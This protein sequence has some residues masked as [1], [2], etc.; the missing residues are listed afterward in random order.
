MGT[1]VASLLKPIPINTFHRAIVSVRGNP[2]NTY[3][4]QA[5]EKAPSDPLFIV[6]GPGSGK[7]TLLTLR[8]LKL[9]IVDQIPARAI[10]ATTFTKKAAA[11]LRS[12]ILGW[13]FKIIDVLKQDTTLDKSQRDW[14]DRMDINQI[15]TGT[16]DSLAE[17]VLREYRQPGQ[18]PPLLADGYIT[19][20]LMLKE[21]LFPN[22]IYKD[23]ELKVFLRQFSGVAY[24][25]G[26]G[27][28]AQVLTAIFDR[29]QHDMVDWNRFVGSVSPTQQ[30]IVGLM[31]QALS[32]YQNALQ[33]LK[34]L[35]FA[36]LEAEFLI[37]LQNGTLKDFADQLQ[38]VLVD[39][40]QDS[41]LLQEQIYFALAQSSK[42]AL[43]V[44]GDD[45][46]SLYRFRGATVELFSD[47]EN[48][49][50]Q[51]FAKQPTQIFLSTNYRS[52]SN[53]VQFVNTFAT[54]DQDYQTVRVANK[55]TISTHPKAISGLPV[56]GMFRDDVQTLGQDLAKFVHD[57]FCGNGFVLPDGQV[58]QKDPVKGAPGDCALLCSSPNEYSGSGKIRLPGVMRDELGQRAPTLEIF[59]PRGQSLTE[60]P[61]V[62]RFAGLL[63]ECLDPG[64]RIQRGIS[65]FN[66]INPILDNWRDEAIN[67][68]ND[69]NCPKG[70]VDYAVGW[71]DR[72]P[73]Q[74]KHVW[75]RQVSFLELLY[76]LVHWFPELHDDPEGQI[77]LEIFTRQASS[78]ETIGK[79]KGQVV[80]NSLKQDIS[81]ASVVEILRNVIAPIASGST[82]INEDLVD[83]FP[84]NRLSVFSIHQSKGLEFPI[85]IVDVG[86]DFKPG[87]G[88]GSHTFKRFPTKS[89]PPHLLE[90]LL[91]P[92]SP[93]LGIP[94]RSGVDRA[95]DDLF[96]LYFVA[97]S[98]AQEVLL[99]VGLN[100]CLPNGINTITTGYDRHGANHWSNFSV[101]QI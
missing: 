77:Y 31:D 10:L 6:A 38:V 20:T 21:G 26:V 69:T 85:T 63:L 62:C 70:L 9:M 22:Q 89:G 19:S 34:M 67:Y 98:R 91:R 3:Q 52:T 78:A 90:D 43:T 2:P 53:I 80:Y 61:V 28:M 66:D 48:R 45:D 4:C 93:N 35:D 82:Q 101:M 92:Y 17:R 86:S 27:G 75:P 1:I 76:G 88:S 47:F 15:I 64:G 72:D 58:I 68:T 12:R 57:I 71:G 55:P 11:E 100:S 5:I 84:R 14:L 83:M 54:M 41:N 16:T 81:D 74:A 65:G 13:G 49:Y 32:S 95:F 99:L 23:D 8:I 51:T 30:P 87:R 40:Y 46:Q 25:F 18:I 33:T 60:I 42:G 7:T 39:E 59:N 56:L 44:V 94:N 29:R 24:R 36:S 79:F 96:R 73:N 97:Y 37:R 50:F